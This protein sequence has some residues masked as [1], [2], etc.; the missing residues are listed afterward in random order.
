MSV[1]GIFVIKNKGLEIG[2][3]I[4]CRYGEG[5]RVIP[6]RENLLRC[7]KTTE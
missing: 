3:K 6:D 5:I 7:L 2:R 4:H 1:P